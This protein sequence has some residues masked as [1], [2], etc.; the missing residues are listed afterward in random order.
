M[1]R[2]DDGLKV[3]FDDGLLSPSTGAA[4]ASSQIRSYF[5]SDQPFCDG[6]M[7]YGEREGNTSE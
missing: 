4:A 6:V 5:F 2:G 3:K 7:E 1:V